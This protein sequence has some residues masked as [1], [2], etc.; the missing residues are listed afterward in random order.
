MEDSTEIKINM[1]LDSAL[2]DLYSGSS[3]SSDEEEVGKDMGMGDTVGSEDIHG[4][5][6]TSIKTVDG[7]GRL[8]AEGEGSRTGREH[9]ADQ[10]LPSVEDVVAKMLQGMSGV[11]GTAT[12]HNDN[13]TTDKEH[14]AVEQLMKEMEQHATTMAG[15]TTNSNSDYD[16]MFNSVMN[17]LLAK[18][19]MYEPMK[20]I[21]DAFPKF[22]QQQRDK[23]SD[24]EYQRYGH[25][26][27]YFQRL[28]RV[29]DTDPENYEKLTELMQDIQQYGQPPP[30]ILQEVAPDLKFNSD[31]LPT[32]EDMPFPTDLDKDCCIM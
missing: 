30:E 11:S 18:D 5:V 31:G 9:M 14:D 3:S 4:E 6:T 23:L 15:E 8:V 32:V 21:T 28:I 12:N 10:N 19:I 2:D 20:Q 25:Q 17:Q 16:S 22:L 24:E 13:G 26:Y 29:Y 27:Q 1:I 7:F